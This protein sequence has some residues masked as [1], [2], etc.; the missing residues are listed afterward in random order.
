MFT[1]SDYSNNIGETLVTIPS[2]RP[3][4][5]GFGPGGGQEPKDE[6]IDDENRPDK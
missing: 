5:T 6:V 4:K 1:E 3:G 2:G